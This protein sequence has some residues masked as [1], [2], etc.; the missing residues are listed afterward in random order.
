[1]GFGHRAGD[2][3]KAKRENA[4]PLLLEPGKNWPDQTSLYTIWLDHDES[5]FHTF[6]FFL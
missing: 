6:H 2:G 5:T 3:Q 1:M 4:E